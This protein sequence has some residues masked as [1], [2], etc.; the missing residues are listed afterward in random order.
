MSQCRSLALLATILAAVAAQRLGLHRAATEGQVEPL[1]V[2]I[3][4]RYDEYNDR[5]KKPDIDGQNAKGHVALHLAL[6]NL[7]GD[8]EVV[9]A[10]LDQNANPNARDRT[11]Q[12]PLHAVAH[13]CSAD[14]EDG[15]SHLLIKAARLLLK[16]GADTE[17]VDAS[18]RTPLHVAASHG[19][20]ALVSMLIAKG[21]N[22]NAQDASGATPLHLAARA[23]EARVVLSLIEAGADPQLEDSAGAMARDAASAADSQSKKIRSYIDDAAGLHA[24]ALEARKQAK[25]EKA[26]AKA[27]A[28]QAEANGKAE[29]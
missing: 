27:A 25:A 9:R 5:W 19:R 4:G 20:T 24:Q 14:E 8:I 1:K 6:C 17:A 21:A 3:R 10:L 2:A 23:L 18:Q 22:P 7:R 26:K 11:G 29:L 28:K 15:S 16:H 13:G 12:A